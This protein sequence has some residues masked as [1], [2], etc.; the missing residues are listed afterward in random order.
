MAQVITCFE[1]EGQ[2]ILH[3]TMDDG[4]QINLDIGGPG[5]QENKDLKKWQQ[6]TDLELLVSGRV[7][8][9]GAL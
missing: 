5:A 7:S 1:K 4:R 6:S 3:I 9:L 8:G 2:L